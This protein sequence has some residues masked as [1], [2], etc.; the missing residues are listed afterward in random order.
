MIA[1][2]AGSAPLLKLLLNHGA[3]VTAVDTA[4]NSAYE[5]AIRGAHNECEEILRNAL[6]V[7]TRTSTPT[8]GSGK[9]DLRKDET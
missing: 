4:G 8:S 1:A 7:D 3:K 9:E 5:L 2:A 6:D